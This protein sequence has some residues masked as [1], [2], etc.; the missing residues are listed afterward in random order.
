M[1][2]RADHLVAR[3]VLSLNSLFEADVT[4]A[5]LGMT[6]TMP[7]EPEVQKSEIIRRAKVG[8]GGKISVRHLLCPN[9]D[10]IE[11]LHEMGYIGKLINKID[12]AEYVFE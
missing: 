4:I 1:H 6:E 10:V 7:L 8:G 11:R 5:G 12:R 3:T 2:L 9:E